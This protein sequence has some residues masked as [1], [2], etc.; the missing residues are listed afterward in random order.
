MVTFK[1][2]TLLGGEEPPAM[3]DPFFSVTQ[4]TTTTN[5]TNRQDVPLCTQLPG[6]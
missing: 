6:S 4:V 2:G 5:T 1:L 3:W